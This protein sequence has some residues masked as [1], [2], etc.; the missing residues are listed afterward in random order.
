MIEIIKSG[1]EKGKKDYTVQCDCGCLF[2]CNSVDLTLKT[3]WWRNEEI[4]CYSVNCPECN[5]QC[6]LETEDKHNKDNGKF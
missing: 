1:K 5:Q 6:N 4:K 2:K 3:T